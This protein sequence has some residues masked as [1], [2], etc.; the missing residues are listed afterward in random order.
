MC[1]AIG[2]DVAAVVDGMGLD[3]RIGRAFL[4]PGPGFGGSCFPS[5]AR[6]LPVLAFRR[7]LRAPLPAVSPSNEYQAD[8]LHR[9]PRG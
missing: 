8:W 5:Q 3:T 4:S 1:A 9:P 2:A 7:R 6:A